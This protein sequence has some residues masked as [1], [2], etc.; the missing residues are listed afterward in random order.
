MMIP[1]KKIEQMA[2]TAIIFLPVL[3]LFHL[4]VIELVVEVEDTICF[5]EIA[6]DKSFPQFGQNLT[7]LG[8]F[9]PHFSQNINN[10]LKLIIKIKTL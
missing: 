4:S 7:L 5:F 1:S 6:L 8:T 3:Q 2:I 10:L 9:V